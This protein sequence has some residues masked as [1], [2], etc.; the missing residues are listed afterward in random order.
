MELINFQGLSCYYN[1]IVSIANHHHMDY[2]LSF[3]ALWSET[4]FTYEPC[5][6]VFLTR[7][8][9]AA[10]EAMGLRL[11]MLPCASLEEAQ[12]SLSLLQ[13][14]EAILIGMDACYIPWS[15][16]Y[17]LYHG[18]HYFIARKTD[19]GILTCLDPTYNRS[20]GTIKAADIPAYAFDISRLSRVPPA[21][22]PTEAIP[23]PEKE[24]RTV[25]ENHPGFCRRLLPA[26]KA[27]IRQEP[28]YALLLARYTDALISNRYLYRCYLNSLPPPLNGCAACFTGEYYTSWTAV[29][30]GLFKANVCRDNKDLI[31]QV[32]IRLSSVILEEINMA[33]TI[34]K[35]C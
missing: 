17:R 33:E 20:D 34:L 24:A 15:P 22:G 7:R 14:G 35:T 10:L 12:E 26:V 5:R 16:L 28:E 32:C 13:D 18:P 2:L 11:Q 27:C 23:L 8:M 19:S 1:C 30:N 3:A 6:Q 31:D 29:K 21:D 25:L 4:D 9:P